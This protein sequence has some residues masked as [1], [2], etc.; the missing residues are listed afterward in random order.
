[1]GY[2]FVP[3]TGKPSAYALRIIGKNGLEQRGIIAENAGVYI[4]P[5]ENTS[6]VSGP[7]REAVF[8][9][10]RLIGID[11]EAKGIKTIVFDN[12]SDEVVVDPED[13]S[14]LTLF[15]KAEAVSHKWV[16]HP[17][18]STDQIY[19]ALGKVI[20]ENN[21]SSRLKLLMPFPDGGIQVIRMKEDGVSAIDKSSLPEVMALMYGYEKRVPIVMFGDGHNDIPAM[22]PDSVIPLTFANAEERVKEFV[23]AKGGHVSQFDAPEGLGV[24]DGIKW[25]LTEKNFFADKSEQVAAAIK[26]LFPEL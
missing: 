4:K 22:T 8:E 10:K 3:V 26:D 21:L 23:Q 15:T 11:P 19:E 20:K 1:M 24:V 17:T 6:Q 18:L 9:L 12:V 14:I 16:F 2:F 13:V 25:L 7:N 5:E